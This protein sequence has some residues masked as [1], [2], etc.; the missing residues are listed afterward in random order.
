[1]RDGAPQKAWRGSAARIA[2]RII[3]LLALLAAG[4]GSPRA[5]ERVRLLQALDDLSMA[6][7]QLRDQKSD[8]AR[9]EAAIAALGPKR[10]KHRKASAPK[11]KRFRIVKLRPSREAEPN[12]GEEPPPPQAEASDQSVADSTHEVMHLYYRGLQLVRE[13]R[14]EETVRPFSLFLSSAPDHVYADRAQYWL[15]EA[16]F[17]NRDH[18]LAVIAAN[19]FDSRFPKSFRLAES[20]YTRALAY[21][22]MGETKLAR[23]ALREVIKRFPD[24]VMADAATRRLGQVEPVREPPA[25][26]AE[27]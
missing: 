23:G 26:L 5:E 13:G 17:R 8:L 14:Y 4:C 3:A 12:P 9:L 25:L 18:G 19:Q 22:S 7:T 2:R 20:M 27:P 21:E 6:Q 1:M 24:D 15:V 11:P 10:G 16:H